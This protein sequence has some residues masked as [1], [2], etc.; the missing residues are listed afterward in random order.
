MKLDFKGGFELLSL[1]AFGPSGQGAANMRTPDQQRRRGGAAA[2]AAAGALPTFTP[3]SAN[4]FRNR[5][6][7]LLHPTTARNA[8]S[9]HTSTTRYFP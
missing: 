4:R 3:A 5:L 6:L 9:T 1:L 8:P 7:G 2:A